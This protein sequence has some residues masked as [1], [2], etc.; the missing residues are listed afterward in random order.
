M[1]RTSSLNSVMFLISWTMV[2][3]YGYVKEV[4]EVG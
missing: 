1:G 4:K 3:S 2:M